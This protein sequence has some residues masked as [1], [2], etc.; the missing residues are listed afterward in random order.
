MFL[1]ESLGIGAAYLLLL[2]GSFFISDVP[3]DLMYEILSVSMVALSLTYFVLFLNCTVVF[4]SQFKN[5]RY[6]LSF[7]AFVAF[8]IAQ[9]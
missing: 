6:A 1:L 5:N 2:C 9:R 3:H 8:K 4:D 7:M